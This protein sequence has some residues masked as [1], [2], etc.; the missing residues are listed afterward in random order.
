MPLRSRPP[1]S[2]LYPKFGRWRNQATQLH[3][4]L[5]LHSLNSCCV[6]LSRCARVVVFDFQ[7]KGYIEQRR[8]PE[9]PS[10]N[11]LPANFIPSILAAMPIDIRLHCADEILRPLNMGT[12]G[13]G[14]SVNTDLKVPQLLSEIVNESSGAVCAVAALIDNQNIV[15]LELAH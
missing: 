5:L 2:L 8:R 10:A 6:L 4:R 1:Y 14:G 13:I 12:R 9:L 15:A 3:Q 11:L 7:A